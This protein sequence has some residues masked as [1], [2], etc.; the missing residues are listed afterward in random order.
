[1][2]ENTM[3]RIFEPFFTTKPEGRGTGLGLSTVYGIVHQNGGWIDVES[4]AGKGTTFRIY[5]PRIATCA[6]E[7]STST[8]PLDALGGSETV[9]VVEDEPA[10]R[11]LITEVLMDYGYSVL[12]ASNGREA[13]QLAENHTGPIHLMVTD[14]IMPGMSGL[15]VAERMS[16]LRHE[17]RVLFMS[18]YND[19][20]SGHGRIVDPGVEF[21]CKPVM[22]NVLAAKVRKILARPDLPNDA[23]GLEHHRPG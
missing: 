15:E 19:D 21:L 2:D 20:L 14:V 13:L 16:V 22:P 6:W 1:M 8:Q 17:I 18:G 3:A 12:G 5:Y 23:K 11:E 4:E 9:L 10:V 7:Q